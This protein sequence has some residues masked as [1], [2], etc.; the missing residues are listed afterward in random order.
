[1]K[2]RELLTDE[3][4]WI[5]GKIA[6]SSNGSYCLSPREPNAA[7]W[8]LWGAVL[9]CYWDEDVLRIRAINRIVE[10]VGRIDSSYKT[11]SSFN[12]DIKTTFKKVKQIIEELDI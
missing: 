4:K 2:V 5:Q 9:K 8:C 7:R 11:I 3:S 12:D 6:Q 10:K 1:M